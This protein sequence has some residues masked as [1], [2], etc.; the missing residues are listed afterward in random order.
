MEELLDFEQVKCDFLTI[1]L[2]EK[3]ISKLNWLCENSQLLYIRENLKVEFVEDRWS[4]NLYRMIDRN[5]NS[6]CQF[7]KVNEKNKRFDIYNKISFSGLFWNLGMEK[8]FEEICNFFELTDKN[9]IT[10]LDLKVDTN[11]F[12]VWELKFK[13]KY[14]EHRKP[15]WT[16]Y[17]RIIVWQDKEWKWKRYTF[18]IY[19][20]NLDIFD[21][22]LYNIKNEEWVK[23][24]DEILK[25][26]ETDTRFEIEFNWKLL[27]EKWYKLWDFR[28]QDRNK[29]MF[30]NLCIQCL[31]L[32]WD[33]KK[34]RIKNIEKEEDLFT[35]YKYNKR[36]ENCKTM[37]NSYS[38]SLKDLHPVEYLKFINKE[39]LKE[40]DILKEKEEILENNLEL[41]NENFEKDLE[42]IRLKKEIEILK[43]KN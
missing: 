23:V 16:Q 12:E 42:I 36:I 10:R 6:I 34:T 40:K 37:I 3:Q 31:E 28:E 39:L 35:Q 13:D 20:K 41:K 17:D 2:E 25:K 38:K 9:K 26:F 7:I 15:H 14:K 29:N 8:Y 21:K 11:K 19:N 27:K 22:K 24:F 5:N 4:Y 30:R 43:N 33:F 32:N 1:R 18:R